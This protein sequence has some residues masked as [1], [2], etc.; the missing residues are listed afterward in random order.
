MGAARHL[1]YRFEEVAK[2]EGVRVLI[3]DRY[4]F[5]PPYF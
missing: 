4:V 5:V 3:I 2:K 1:I